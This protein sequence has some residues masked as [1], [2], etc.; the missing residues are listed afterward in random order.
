MQRKLLPLLLTLV[1][2]L[3][4]LANLYAAAYLSA[5]APHPLLS[6]WL[7]ELL[8]L[9]FFHF[10]RSYTLLL[11][12]ALVVSAVNVYRRKAR[13]WQLTLTLAVF[14]ALWHSFKDQQRWQ[15]VCALLLVAALLYARR[16][17]T[18]QSRVPNWR[19]AALRFAIALLAAFGYG[20][21][22]FWLLEPKEFGVN[23]NWLDS[24][25]Q[26]FLCLSLLG[27]AALVPQTRHAEWFLDSLEVLTF[28]AL[29]YGLLALFRPMLYRWRTLP[30]ERE[31][32][33]ELLRHYGRAA[34]DNFKLWPDKS[35]FFN[36][37][38]DCFIAYRVAAHMAV[39]LGDPVG[40]PDK[41][42]ATIR[43]FKQY[44]EDQ[45]WAVAWHQTQPD[46]LP[47]YRQAG[48]KKLK[49][50]D[51]AVV[52]L[53]VFTLVSARFKRFRE[54]ARQ[55]ERQ[56]VQFKQYAAPLSDELIERLRTVSDEWLQ[57]PGKR[58][59]T[60]TLGRFAPEYPAILD[61]SERGRK[62]RV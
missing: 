39:T 17:F 62:Q 35:Y 36:A 38:H 44:C 14:S 1:T 45:G 58:E 57:L 9:E 11:G 53:T 6:L 15:A 24:I 7:G 40:A 25:K 56:G 21:A 22:G 20:V 4:G 31:R 49:I 2:L 12:F 18:V 46:L 41:L 47:L 29:G 5:H 28:V 55:L 16:S 43:E 51:D 3:N 54:R 37:A 26:T 52:D 32:A 59:R 19:A 42:A 33:Q 23:F 10:P 30:Q 34:L 13:A 27:D 48:F 50:G 8:P 60:F 61:Q